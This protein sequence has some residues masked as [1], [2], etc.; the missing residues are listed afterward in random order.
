MP[1]TRTMGLEGSETGKGR[2]GGSVVGNVM[3][4]FLAGG[5]VV[6]LL[7]RRGVE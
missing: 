3:G 7:R 2:V 1:A 6:W 5:A 4:F